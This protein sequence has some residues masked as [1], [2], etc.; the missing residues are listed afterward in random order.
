MKDNLNNESSKLLEEKRNLKKILE[1]KN[2]GFQSL[3][4][5]QD[6]LDNLKPFTNCMLFLKIEAEKLEL[7][8]QI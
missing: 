2:S 8:M 1:E 7:Y 6:W 5:M 3:C 4:W